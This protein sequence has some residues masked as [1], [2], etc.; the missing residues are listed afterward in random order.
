MSQ[1]IF[2]D[3]ANDPAELPAPAIVADEASL[4]ELVHA[5]DGVSEFGVDTEADSFY[6]Y[7]E[8]VCLLQISVHGI[9]YLVDPLAELDLAPLGEIFANPGITKIFHDGEFD[10]SIL[11]R[12]FGFRFRNLFDTRIAAAALGMEAPGLASVLNHYF[13]LEIDKSEQRSDWSRRPLKQSQV[14]YARLDTR[15][16]HALKGRMQS[17]LEAK[18][19]SMVLAGECTRLEALEVQPR[20]FNPD[21]FVRIKGARRLS[22]TDQS[23]LRE[24]FVLR[25]RIARERDVPPFK[26]LGNPVLLALVE[27]TPSSLSALE[28]LKGFPRGRMRSLGRDVLAAIQTGKSNGPLPRVKSSSNGDQSKRLG[29]P[30]FELHERLRE[31]RRRTAE[32]EDMDSSL[33]LNRHVMLRLALARPTSGEE[34][35]AGEGLVEWQRERY[36]EVLLKLVSRFETQLAA[37][38]IDFDKRRRRR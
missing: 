29:D 18:D 21:D 4:A 12:E 8:K 36:G 20:E 14:E 28:G 25:D 6:S 30:E 19:R 17:D 22:A 15:Y 23:V 35:A 27:R 7:R 9:D 16:L 34:L 5:L 24:L 3:P 2:S 31:W 10:V 32:A 13:G 1:A 33:I 38:K 37:N 11:G 26:V